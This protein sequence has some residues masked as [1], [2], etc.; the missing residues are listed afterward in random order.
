MAAAGLTISDWRIPSLCTSYWGSLWRY[1]FV[2]RIFAGYI[3][4]YMMKYTEK[5]VPDGIDLIGSIIL[6]TYS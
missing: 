1:G 5:Y 6:R 3:V 2:T 4:G